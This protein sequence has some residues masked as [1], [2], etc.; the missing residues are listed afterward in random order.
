MV[1]LPTGTN[2]SDALQKTKLLGERAFGLVE[3]RRGLVIRVK[4]QDFDEVLKLVRPDDHESLAGKLYEVSGLPCWMGRTAL[5]RFCGVWSVLPVTTFRTGDMRTWIVR[6]K[7]A[8]ACHLKQHADGL[9]VFKEAVPKPRKNVTVERWKEPAARTPAS[10]ATK[11]YAQV[12]AKPSPAAKPAA[13][14]ATQHPAAAQP[15]DA[16]AQ[17]IAQMAVLTQ[18]VNAGQVTMSALQADIVKMKS[19]FSGEVELSGDAAMATGAGAS[20]LDPIGKGGKHGKGKVGHGATP[21]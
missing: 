16:L 8:P 18:A 13:A 19:E 20:D 1:V 9:A 21:Y 17:L 10:T 5:A 11:S 7:E 2:L 14:P 6:A 4:P 3:T 12:V 15:V